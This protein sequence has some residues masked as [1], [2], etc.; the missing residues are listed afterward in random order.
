[1]HWPRNDIGEN[2]FKA[3]IILTRMICNVTRAFLTK[4]RE[5]IMGGNH[6]FRNLQY[7]RKRRYEKMVGL[8]FAIVGGLDE[9]RTWLIVLHNNMNKQL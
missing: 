6:L 8:V 2:H 7:S 3:K 5:R 1:M 9:F 4:S